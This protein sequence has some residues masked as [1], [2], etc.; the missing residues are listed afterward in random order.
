MSQKEPWHPGD[1]DGTMGIGKQCLQCSTLL[2][3]DVDLGKRII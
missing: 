2:V 3:V 1:A